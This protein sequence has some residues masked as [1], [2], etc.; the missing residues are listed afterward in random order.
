M[1]REACGEHADQGF[2][3][4]TFLRDLAEKRGLDS[5][6]SDFW[7]GVVSKG[8]TLLTETEAEN[9]EVTK[10]EAQRWLQELKVP[11]VATL[12]CSDTRKTCT[13]L[14]LFQAAC[15]NAAS[16]T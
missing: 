4:N 13:G 1:L 12:Q 3:F 2:V 8:I 6:H 7:Q 10:E 14:M 15:Q 16:C 9:S 5:G 11:K